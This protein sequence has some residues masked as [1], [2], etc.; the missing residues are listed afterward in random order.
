M[1]VF[2]KKLNEKQ[3]KYDDSKLKYET[4][5]MKAEDDIVHEKQKITAYYKAKLQEVA[6]HNSQDYSKRI[7]QKEK[8]AERKIRDLEQELKIRD[9]KFETQKQVYQKEIKNKMEILNSKDSIIAS[10]TDAKNK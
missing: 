5:L 9:E 4:Q 7:A 6:E 2:L 3:R 8:E 10:L 1:D